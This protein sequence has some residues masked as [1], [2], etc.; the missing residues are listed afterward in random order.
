MVS[1][2]AP[3][4]LEDGGYRFSDGFVATRRKIMEALAF[5]GMNKSALEMMTHITGKDIALVQAEMLHENHLKEKEEKERIIRE[6][7]ERERK[8]Q[9]QRANAG[10]KVVE[11]GRVLIIKDGAVLDTIPEFTDEEYIEIYYADTHVRTSTPAGKKNFPAREVRLPG[12]YP[13]YLIF[14]RW[15]SGVKQ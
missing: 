12:R 2:K 14:S 11:E 4:K 3:E 9:Q 5:A 8:R 6:A 13:E 7:A 15:D 10:K 1:T